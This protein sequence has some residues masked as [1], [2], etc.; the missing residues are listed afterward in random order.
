MFHRK[1]K[2]V[3][4]ITKAVAE[5]GRYNFLHSLAKKLK[6]DVA[7]PLEIKKAVFETNQKYCQPP[8]PQMEV[9]SIIKECCFR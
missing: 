1:E 7:C 8:L 4:D 9:E 2:R 5:G 6:E 3:K